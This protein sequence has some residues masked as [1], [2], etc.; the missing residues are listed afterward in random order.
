MLATDKIANM[1]FNVQCGFVYF[2]TL[3]FIKMFVP[4]DTLVLFTSENPHRRK[5]FFVR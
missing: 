3:C 4:V 5:L 1:L 2:D